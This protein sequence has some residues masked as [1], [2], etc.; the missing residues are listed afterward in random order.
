M[1]TPVPEWLFKEDLTVIGDGEGTNELG[2]HIVE[3]GNIL[4]YLNE[5]GKYRP[6]QPGEE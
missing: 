6:K 5:K 2:E 1:A 4:Y 3:G